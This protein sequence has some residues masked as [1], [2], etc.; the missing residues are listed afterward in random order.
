M[1]QGWHGGERTRLPALWP[2]F[3]LCELRLLVLYPVF[4]SPQKP[5][6]NLTQVKL[7]RFDFCT[8]H[9][10]YLNTVDKLFTIHVHVS[11]DVISH[12]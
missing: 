2:G 5:S 6:Y 1:A 4:P 12:E 3:D 11:V 10:H 9:Q 7:T 8:V